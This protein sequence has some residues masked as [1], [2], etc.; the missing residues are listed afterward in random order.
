ME[1]SET[2]K[3]PAILKVSEAIKSI[4]YTTA[5]KYLNLLISVFIVRSW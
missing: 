2:K 5:I 1:D 4:K 3:E